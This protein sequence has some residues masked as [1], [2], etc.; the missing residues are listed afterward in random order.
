[1]ASEESYN[2]ND[3]HSE[4]D[5]DPEDSGPQGLRVRIAKK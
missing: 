4:D 5:F 2:I 3:E 1:M